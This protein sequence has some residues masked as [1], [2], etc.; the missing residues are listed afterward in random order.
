MSRLPNR[1]RAT[2]L[3]GEQYCG[4]RREFTIAFGACATNS[5]QQ[6]FLGNFRGLFVP[7]KHPDERGRW[8]HI[9]MENLREKQ[10]HI[11]GQMPFIFVRDLRASRLVSYAQSLVL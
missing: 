10:N 9:S 2:N 11:Q 5:T 1:R 7:I 6:Y 8:R 3:E 4:L